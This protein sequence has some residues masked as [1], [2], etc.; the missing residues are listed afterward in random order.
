M[1]FL[2]PNYSCLQNPWLRG[3]S[4]Q[5]PVISFLW[6]QLNLLNPPRKKFLGTPLVMSVLVA[7]LTVKEC[8]K[9]VQRLYVPNE[10][11]WAIL[12]VVMSCVVGSLAFEC[13]M[14]IWNCRAC[15]FL[16]R[17]LCFGVCTPK[18]VLINIFNFPQTSDIVQA[19]HWEINCR[20]HFRYSN[21]CIIQNMV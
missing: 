5:I 3:Y 20:L 15:L 1:K 6:P 16:L 21:S 11:R 17:L 4:P 12:C 10:F 7:V 19:I 13:V 18:V 9:V 14:R 2:V 8:H